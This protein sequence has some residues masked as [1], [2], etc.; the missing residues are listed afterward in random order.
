MSKSLLILL[1]FCMPLVWVRS[2]STEEPTEKAFQE[3]K[4]YE[5]AYR[6][7]H[8]TAGVKN[9]QKIGL[10]LHERHI[11][12]PVVGIAGERQVAPGLERADHVGR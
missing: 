8:Q 4:T 10:A 3:P 7:A 1:L 11:A 9:L 5:E 2:A 6:L 12:A